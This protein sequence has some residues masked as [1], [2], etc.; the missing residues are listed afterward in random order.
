MRD[1]EANAISLPAGDH[2]GCW[3]DGAN[4][5][6]RFVVP[7]PSAFITMRSPLRS[8]AILFPSGDQA[9]SVSELATDCDSVVTWWAP[10]PLAL[11]TQIP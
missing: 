4:A 1:C 9:G 11:T 6:V 8:N 7:L 5:A 3:I 2:E 10:V